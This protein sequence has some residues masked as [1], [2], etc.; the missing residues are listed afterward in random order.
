MKDLLEADKPPH[1]EIMA[2]TAISEDSPFP[3]PTQG[4]CDSDGL[5]LG[6]DSTYPDELLT[7]GHL[8]RL[9]SN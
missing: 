7:T 1:Q 3:C 9:T 6:P 2:E 4:S 8:K 5:L